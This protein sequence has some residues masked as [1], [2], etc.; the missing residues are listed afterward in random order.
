MNK[1][2]GVS[3]YFIVFRYLVSSTNCVG[4]LPSSGPHTARA[5]EAEPHL[6]RRPGSFVNQVGQVEIV[7]L[8]LQHILYICEL[9]L[10]K[11]PWQQTGSFSSLCKRGEEQKARHMS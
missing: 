7:S 4:M 1:N 9:V 2:D 6:Y 3:F 11:T 8:T 5:A 10:M